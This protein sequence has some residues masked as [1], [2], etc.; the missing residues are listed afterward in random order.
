MKHIS[1]SS[2]S[3]QQVAWSR[4]LRF[5]LVLGLSFLLL[6]P[7]AMAQKKPTPIQMNDRNSLV[8]SGTTRMVKGIIFADVGPVSRVVVMQP[9]GN[10]AWR[11]QTGQPLNPGQE[12]YIYFDGIPLPGTMVQVPWYEEGNHCRPFLSHLFIL[13][14]GAEGTSAG[15]V[16]MCDYIEQNTE[17]CCLLW[18][19]CSGVVPPPPPPQPPNPIG[20]Q[21]T[22]NYACFGGATYPPAWENEAQCT[23]YGC[24]FGDFSRDQCLALGTHKGARE[25]VHGI[26]GGGRS[27]ECWLQDS[28]ADVRPHSEFVFFRAGAFPPPPPQPIGYQDRGAYACFGGATYP[29]AW[30]QEA[31]C[32][33][34]GCYFGQMSTQECLALGTSKSAGEVIHGIAGGGRSN[35]CWLQTSCTDLRPHQAFTLF[36]P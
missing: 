16:F 3:D 27:N 7:A 21:S 23:G 33:G 18:G 32:T 19:D 28:C 26:A 22:G 31:Q 10:A 12:C 25:V 11:L 14:W 1:T 36:Q 29:S 30:E 24:Y 9:S 15:S 6:A 35:E 20:Y 8:F 2:S 4:V 5:I 34:V 17:P 13:T